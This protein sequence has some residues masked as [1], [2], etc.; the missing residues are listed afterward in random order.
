[1]PETLL[2]HESFQ[3]I[4]TVTSKALHLSAHR[5]AYQL[6]CAYE[7]LALSSVHRHRRKNWTEHE[8]AWLETSEKFLL[9]LA[10]IRLVT[11][12]ALGLIICHQILVLG[13]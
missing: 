2:R 11:M 3:K 7:I 8:E 12:T 9:R 5:V 10:V 13:A 1:M 4:T 6:M